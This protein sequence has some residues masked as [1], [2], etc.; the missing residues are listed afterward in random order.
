MATIK[1]TVRGKKN[2]SPIYIRFAEGKNI[3]LHEKSGLYV[4]PI[5]WDQK[6]Q[7]IRKVLEVA[8]KDDI[9]SNL[10]KLEIYLI[11]E[12]NQSF[13]TG[14]VINKQWLLQSIQKFFNRPKN[15]EKLQNL[16]HHIYFSDYAQHWIDNKAKKFKVAANKY[17]DE[18]TIGHYQQVLD[19]F[20]D[21]EGKNK[22]KLCDLSNLKL[23]EFSLYLSDTKSYSESTSKR[24]VGRVKFFCAR[25]ESDN[26]EV[27]KQYKERVFVKEQEIEYKQPYLNED[28]INNIF[29]LKLEPNCPMDHVRDNLII[30]LWTGLRVSD[31]LTR[32]NVSNIQDGFI[33]IKTM[34][35]KTFVNIPIHSQVA[36]ILNKRNGQLPNK[37]SEQKFND[38]IK[39]LTQI[40]GIDDLMIGGVMKVD[41]KTKV[42]RKVIDTYKKWELMTSHV[43]RRSFATN[44]FGK[45]SN[46][47]ICD[48]CGWSNEDMLFAYNKTTNMESAN[49]L[50]D[51]WD[52]KYESKI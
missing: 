45:V 24:K 48:V 26:L 3:D 11:D 30:G 19:N 7:Q 12:F 44:L 39:T 15:E 27:N 51:Y 28:E 17:M 47:T 29:K 20:K 25:A 14:Q 5:F 13:M 1:F 52:K 6:K 21:F 23:D 2:P 32:L 4:N 31:F 35:T 36:F 37:I 10:R 49:V 33:K 43:G 34:K 18:T 8:N 42:K 16:K 46:K 41:E 9:N 22:V 38:H 50:K 40:V